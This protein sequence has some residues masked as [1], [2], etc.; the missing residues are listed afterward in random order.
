MERDE[1]QFLCSKVPLAVMWK[2]RV[3]KGKTIKSL[4]EKFTQEVME[5]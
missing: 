5:V 3:D 2:A 4:L 1:I